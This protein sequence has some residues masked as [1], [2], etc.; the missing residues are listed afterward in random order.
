MTVCFSFCCICCLYRSDGEEDSEDDVDGGSG[1][2]APQIIRQPKKK[3]QSGLSI[4]SSSR[5]PSSLQRS[6]SLALDLTMFDAEQR[7]S[8]LVHTPFK[9]SGFAKSLDAGMFL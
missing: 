7:D 5:Q 8:E 1:D 6:N 3:Q 2:G 9:N 4:Q